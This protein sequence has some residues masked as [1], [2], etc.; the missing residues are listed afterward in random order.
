M[1]SDAVLIAGPTASG[2]SALGLKLAHALNGVIVNADSM[3]L[4]K[5]LPVLTARPDEEMLATA[6]HRLYGVLSATEASSAGNYLELVRQTLGEIYAEKRLPIFVS[7]TGLYFRAR[8]QGLAVIPPIESALRDRLR[9]QLAQEGAESVLA[10]MR[11][12]DAE[13]A[14]R[15]EHSDPQRLLRAAEVLLGTGRSLPAWQGDSVKPLLDVARVK[16]IVILPERERLYARINARFDAMMASGALEE[17]RA[18][19][20]LQLPAHMPAMKILGAPQLLGHL[21]GEIDLLEAQEKAKIMSRRYAKRQFTWFRNQKI[22]E[23]SII[24]EDSERN[25]SEILSFIRKLP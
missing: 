15:V 18:L 13:E 4:Y 23:N 25:I 7:G 17:A 24:V 20:R 21:R 2:K 14:G 19:A 8:T 9:V 6:P 22:A 11:A 16:V 12:H 1:N 5:E 3:Q 10:D